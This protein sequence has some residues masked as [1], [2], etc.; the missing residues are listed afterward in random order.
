M[1]S[2]SRL[3]GMVVI[4]KK[5]YIFLYKFSVCR[6]RSSLKLDLFC[7]YGIIKAIV[8]WR[9]GCNQMKIFSIEEFLAQ[10]YLLRKIN[11]AIDFTNIYE[12]VED[13][14]C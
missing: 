14:Y 13:L 7:I 6:K 10:E 4:Y 11:S 5:T 1:L 3:S 2:I 12:I 9:E 8:K